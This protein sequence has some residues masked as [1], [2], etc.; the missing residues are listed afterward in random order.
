LGSSSGSSPSSGGSG[1]SG[2]GSI[3]AQYGVFKPG[4]IDYNT[5]AVVVY[6]RDLDPSEVPRIKE[7]LI[8]QTAAINAAKIPY[9]LTGPNS[10]SVVATLM[11]NAGFTDF[12]HEG[13]LAPGS[14][15]RLIYPNGERVSA[16]VGVNDFVTNTE[17]ERTRLDRVIP[18]LQRNADTIAR[19]YNLNIEKPEDLAKA[20]AK[21]WNANGLNHQDLIDQ[22]PNSDSGAIVSALAAENGVVNQRQLG[23]E[24]GS[25]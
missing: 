14:D 2:F 11:E 25:A 18:F 21:Y 3:L 24:P 17:D 19:D 1:E 7:Q 6:Q 20:V 4:S 13:I 22:L 12:S 16:E 5:D 15:Q 23:F 9:K 10:N 8:S